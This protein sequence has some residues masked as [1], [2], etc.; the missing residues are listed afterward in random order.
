MVKKQH[1][2]KQLKIQ[3]RII[4]FTVKDH[5]KAL[6]LYKFVS[7][8]RGANKC[9]RGGGL[10]PGM[11]NKHFNKRKR[12]RNQQNPDTKLYLKNGSELTYH[13][14]DKRYLTCFIGHS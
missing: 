11:A 2:P 12:F 1:F 4:L 14:I 9:R 6:G 7:V 13:D 8:F 10:C 3:T 5:N